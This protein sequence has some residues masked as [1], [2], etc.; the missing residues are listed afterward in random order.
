[1]STG[2]HV[3]SVKADTWMDERL[4]EHIKGCGH[5][6]PNM[7]KLKGCE[8]FCEALYGGNKSKFFWT[9]NMSSKQLL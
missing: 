4:I 1:M 9:N 3:G 8:Y 2:W 7:D 5:N 6:V